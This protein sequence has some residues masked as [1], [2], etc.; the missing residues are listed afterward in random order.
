MLSECWQDYLQDSLDSL[1]TAW[2]CFPCIFLDLQALNWSQIDSD[3]EAKTLGQILNFSH[4]ISDSFR[5]SRQLCYLSNRHTELAA[6]L[7]RQLRCNSFM[8]K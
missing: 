4:I 5:A 8:Q 2:E 1:L 7:A 6:L 3:N